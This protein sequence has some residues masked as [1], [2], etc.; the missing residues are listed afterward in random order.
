MSA[1]SILYVSSG[2][3]KEYAIKA[4]LHA[5]GIKLEEIVN[6]I[7][8]INGKLYNITLHAKESREDNETLRNLT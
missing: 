5:D 7:L 2:A 8:Y 6:N 1:V 3:A 4:I